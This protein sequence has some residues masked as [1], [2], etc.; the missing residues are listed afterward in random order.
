MSP[1][2]IG[3]D[4]WDRAKRRL[5]LSARYGY[6]S[7]MFRDPERANTMALSVLRTTAQIAH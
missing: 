3:L 4:A 7:P 2:Y 6:E 1:Y 5:A